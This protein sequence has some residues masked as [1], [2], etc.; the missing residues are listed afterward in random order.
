M[1]IGIFAGFFNILAQRNNWRE[2]GTKWQAYRGKILDMCL[3]ATFRASYACVGLHPTLTP[4]L[5]YNINISVTSLEIFVVGCIH[6]NW[7]GVEGFLYFHIRSR[8]VW[9][10]YWHQVDLGDFIAC[11]LPGSHELTPPGGPEN[12]FQGPF[13]EHVLTSCLPMGIPWSTLVV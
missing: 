8:N 4:W 12:L 3:W 1:Q 5:S 6:C 9:L 2:T 10:H 13:W 11:S 7:E